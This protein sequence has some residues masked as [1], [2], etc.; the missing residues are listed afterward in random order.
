MNRFVDIHANIIPDM[1]AVRYHAPSERSAIQQLRKAETENVKTVVATP[2][3]DTTLYPEA[4][5]F[6]EMRR[7]RCAELNVALTDKSSAL[8]VMGGAI[9][10][11]DS[12]LLQMGGRLRRFTLA[13]SRYLLVDLPDTV[14]SANF[15][16]EIER[17]R[18]YSGLTPI[19]ADIDR[20]YNDL[21]LHSVQRLHD[22]GVLLQ[23]SAD[24]LL[25]LERRNFSLYLLSN[26]YAHFIAS[27]CQQP[28]KV[29]QIA[30]AMRVAQRMLPSELYRR[31][32]NNAGMLLADPSPDDF[33]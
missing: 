14:F 29:I 12:S 13:D 3:Y 28:S 25:S 21:D 30:D 18:L 20:F 17:F 11:Y 8:R 33:Q 7:M 31:I 16:A 1:Q 4:D 23:I 2:L 27:G 32:K 22:A 26:K 19:V 15:F 6:L 9:V 5:M 24:G 10:R